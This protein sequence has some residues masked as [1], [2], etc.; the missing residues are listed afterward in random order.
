MSLRDLLQKTISSAIKTTP[1]SGLNTDAICEELEEQLVLADVSLETTN[2]LIHN[3]RRKKVFSGP[4]KDILAALALELA[5]VIKTAPLAFPRHETDRQV[6]ILLGVNGSGKTTTAAK[7]AYFHREQGRKILLCAADTFRAAG[8]SQLEIWA[9]KLGFP[10]ISGQRGS[11]PGAVVFNSLQSFLKR[12]LDTLIIDTA[13]RLQN[14]EN[15]LKELQKIIHLINRTIPGQ[16]R[17]TLLVLD[18]ATGQNALSQTEK[19]REFS[20]VNGLILTRFDGTAKGGTLITIAEKTGLPVLAL[21]C[22]E[23]PADLLE[24]NAAEFIKAMIA[25]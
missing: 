20:A 12:E 4:E 3:L 24:F 10:V 7:L 25:V 18:A 8:A 19:F 13:G 23:E 6:I 9:E 1:R 11:D 5:S 14:R 2:R 17:Q 21:G 22:G 15:L 16:P